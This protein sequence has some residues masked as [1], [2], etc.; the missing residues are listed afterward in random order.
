MRCFV[1]PARPGSKR[2]LTVIPTLYHVK[3]AKPSQYSTDIRNNPRA[4]AVG[5]AG[6]RAPRFQARQK[7][8][9]IHISLPHFQQHTHD[10]PHHV[11][12]KSASGDAI[13]QPS[14]SSASREQKMVRTFD[15]SSSSRSSDAANAVKSCSPSSSGASGDHFFDRQRIRMMANIAPFERRTDLA[16]KNAIFVS[17][18]FGLEARMKIERGFLHAAAR[19]CR[20]AAADSWR[21][22]DYPPESDSRS[23][24]PP[25]APSA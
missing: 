24:T 5:P 16:A 10:V 7:S 18:P 19:E 11:L 2:F 9:A 3:L 22:A 8:R 12:Q 17:L 15:S 20:A 13:N 6:I 25:P 23:K 4:G 1:S 14:P 21:A